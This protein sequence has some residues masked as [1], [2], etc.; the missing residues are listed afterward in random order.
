[1]A[2]TYNYLAEIEGYGVTEGGNREEGLVEAK[3]L[4][5]KPVVQLCI[6]S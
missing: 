5:R 6:R 3:D 4:L 2:D 1:M